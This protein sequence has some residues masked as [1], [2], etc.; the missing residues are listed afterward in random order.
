MRFVP[1]WTLAGTAAVLCG[2]QPDVVQFPF[3]YV[4]TEL[5]SG[6]VDN[7][8]AS[9]RVLYAG[10]VRL[11]GAL[12]IRLYFDRT[13]LPEGTRLRL[14]SVADGA[15]EIFDGRSLADYQNYSSWFN[16]DAVAVE[17]LGGARTR[18]NRVR[19]VGADAGQG[20]VQTPSTICGPTDDRVPSTDPR[21][22]RQYPTGC[23][24]WLIDLHTVVTA[25]HCTAS[26]AQQV[27][28]NVP[29]SSSTGT[30]VLPPPEHQYRYDTAAVQR[31]SA[32]V[33]Q[34]WTVAS[35]LRNATTGLYA[36][37][38]QGGYYELVTP[39]AFAGG[40]V[41]RITGY[42]TDTDNRDRSQTQQTHTGPRVNVTTA[43]AVGYQTDTTGGN[44]GSPVILES[45][46]QAIGVHT[47]G[48]CSSS[49]T[50][51]NWGTAFNRP[52]WIAA[53]ASIR[54]LKH[55][56]AYA[57]FGDG[58]GSG[59]P[60]S[61]TNDGFPEIGRSMS[62]VM[63]NLPAL[64]PAVFVIGDRYTSPIDLTVVRMPGCFLYTSSLAAPVVQADGTG[65]ARLTY[66][67][68]NEV[69]LVGGQFTVQGAVQDPA[70]NAAGV[71]MS[72]AGEST[73]GQ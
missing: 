18:A 71:A 42:G 72:N 3:H 46:G 4:A 23:T 34:D 37:Q 54:A 69:T 57:V 2:Q 66:T 65:E 55:P 43:N 7:A 11:A 5:D 6:Y 36:G 51:N 56:G 26:T 31:L 50:G 45:T 32:G 30:I 38:R 15:I 19:V 1:L 47:H 73:I 10:H 67:V 68:P 62:A 8:D 53:V 64:A 12:Q 61:L 52:D 59:T 70:A 16:G 22:G 41:I 25:G 44:S 39:P 40:Q 35:T 58:C 33:G 60:P 24:S 14:T 28:F 63:T 17:L 49:G 20:I 21:Q 29:P 9:P 48:G 27:H 13:N